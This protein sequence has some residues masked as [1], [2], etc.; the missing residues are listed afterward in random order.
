MRILCTLIAAVMA[1]TLEC[2][3][4][5]RVSSPSP[6]EEIYLALADEM[7]S[8]LQ[9]EILE[10]WF[11][12]A[13]D[14][15]G[16]GFFENYSL[17]W[18]RRPGS[19]RSIV[20]QS[21]LTW[22][23]AQAALRFPDQAEFYLRMTRHGTACLLER[24]WDQKH[25]GFYWS[26]DA[27]GQPANEGAEHKHIYGVAFGLYALTASYQATGDEATLEM[28]KKVFQWMEEHAHDSKNKGYYE[29]VALDGSYVEGGTNPIGARADQKSMNTHI[30]V[31][32]ALTALYQIWQDPEVRTRV[33]EVLEICR[34]R[35]YTEPGY[36]T[37]FFTADWQRLPGPDSFGHDVETGF[38]MV[39]AAEALGRHDDKQVWTAAR[40]LVDHALLYGW[41]DE[42][43]GLYDAGAIN[44]EGVVTGDLHTE[45]IWWVQ[46]E[47]LNALMLMHERFGN[48]TDRYW[49]A[50]FQ[51]WEFI[52]KYQIDHERGG[53][54]PTVHA[55]GEPASRVKSNRWTECYH[56][57]RAMLVVSERLRRLAQDG[58]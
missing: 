40:R 22:T 55:N 10:R 47:S 21:R 2:I 44:A 33:Q 4:A 42:F 32:E 52:R 48:E 3:A 14:E 39:E 29:Y 35:I 15:E 18:T 25:G 56:Q 26:I 49:D 11:P 17:D 9:K 23:A 24:M 28:A 41:D 45:K 5:D 16:G 19:D 38:L 31:L 53:W 20:Y 46:A 43:G 1:C 54:Y 36:L 13:V 27:S 30:H 6:N 7:E 50:F 58:E 12:T 57:A 37:Q 51:Q 8:S 34:D